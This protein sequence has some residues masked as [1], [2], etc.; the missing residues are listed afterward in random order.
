MKKDDQVEKTKK[1]ITKF[2]SCFS[3]SEYVLFTFAGLVA[4]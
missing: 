4:V 1:K 3:Y 2:R